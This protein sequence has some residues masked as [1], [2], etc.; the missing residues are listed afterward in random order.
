MDDFS[1]GQDARLRAALAYSSYTKG[2][3]HHFY[4]YPARFSPEFAHAVIDEFSDEDDLVLDPFMGGGTSIIEGVSLGRRMVGVDINALGHFVAN[5]RTTPLSTAD[6]TA[7]LEWARDVATVFSDGTFRSVQL[8]GIRNLPPSLES[9]LAGAL[10][11]SRT[12]R[13]PRQ[14][15]LARCAL[16]RVGQWA[17]E[18]REL[19]GPRRKR[20][21]RRLVETASEMIQG[22]RDFVEQCSRSSIPKNLITSRRRL[23]NRNTVGLDAEARLADLH[24]QVR[25]VVTSPPYPGVHVNYHRWQHQGRKETPAPYWIA[26]V[27]DGCGESFYTFGSRKAFIEHGVKVGMERYSRILV[28]A[29]TSVRPYLASGALVFQLIAFPHPEEQLPAYLGAMQMAGYEEVLP[30]RNR[31][32]RQVPNRRWYARNQGSIGAAAEVLL[33]H[34]A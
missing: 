4:H 20:L 7:F 15:A 21:A 9:F 22:M 18:S 30:G 19:A 6:E 24:E 12:L 23:L 11:M 26:N 14:R 25:L 29:F 33:I 5:V 3:T 10:V 27:S 8:L 32:G 16:L 2:K 1:P 28:D 17:M 34:R 31:P 13:F